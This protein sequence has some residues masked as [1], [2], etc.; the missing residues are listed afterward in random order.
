[1][2]RQKGYRGPIIVLTAHAK[3]G[4]REECINADCDDNAAKPIDRRKL[5]DTVAVFVA[6]AA[7]EPEPVHSYASAFNSASRP[8]SR[9]RE[10][11]D[12]RKGRDSVPQSG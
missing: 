8:Q 11:R 9:L 1:M 7:G 4:D 3:E 10:R 6:P 12:R 2:L 5:I